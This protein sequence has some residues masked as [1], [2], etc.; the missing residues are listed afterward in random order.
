LNQPD[1]I[2]STRFTPAGMNEVAKS[3]KEYN[4]M[5]TTGTVVSPSSN[6]VNFTCGSTTNEMETILS[7]EGA[8]GYTIDKVFTDWTPAT[9]AAQLEA[10]AATYGKGLVSWTP[11]NNGAI[12]YLIEKND[13]FVGITTEST[14][15]VEAGAD[16]VLTIRAA[17]GRGGFGQAKTVEANTVTVTLNSAGYA[18]LASDKALD[19]SSVEGLTAYIV[20]TTSATQA[21]LT[22]VDAAPAETGLV[23]KGA[24]NGEYEI[25]VVASA[26]A[27]EGNLLVAAVTATEVTANTVY[28][29][30]GN[31]F[32][33]FADTKIPAGK[34][35]L[36]MSTGARLLELVF[37]DATGIKSIDNSRLTIDNYYNL[38]G[39][40]VKPTKKGIYVVDGKKVIIK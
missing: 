40:Q 19:F 6:V 7:E 23:L 34:A 8:A 10:P 18:T 17:N 30:N 20:T 33:V 24:E 14:F 37:D 13:E 3:F 38:S 27:V 32:K 35:Y 5:N 9:Y 36:P 22:S 21:T 4:S 25:P 26:A 29:L 12:A 1:E 15:E 16:D 11:A 28:V 31:K 2:I 39:Q